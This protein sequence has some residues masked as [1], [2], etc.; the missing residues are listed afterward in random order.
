MKY[1]ILLCG[2]NYAAS[3]LHSFLKLPQFS[4]S[5][6]LA[7]GSKRSQ[8]L[9]S[10]FQVPLYQSVEAIN[11]PIDIAIVA[12]QQE[13][14]I[15]IAIQLMRKGIAV[16]LEHP[17]SNE[18]LKHLRR[19]S[20]Q[21]QVVFHVNPHFSYLP[22][23]EKFIQT[24]QSLNAST[25]PQVI[26]VHTSPR[27]LYS[28]LDILVKSFGQMFDLATLQVSSFQAYKV[29]SLRIN[30]IPF[31][32]NFQAWKSSKDNWSDSLSGHHIRISYH[33]GIL[34]LLGASG[35]CTWL[36]SP[37]Y[38]SPNDVLW[39]A[40]PKGSP[41]TLETFSKWRVHANQRSL[42]SLVQH[43]ETS[44]TPGDQSYLHLDYLTLFY[45]RFMLEFAPIMTKDWAP[46]EGL[47]SQK[48]FEFT[49]D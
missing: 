23:V 5:G 22:P 11:Q 47:P 27:C 42:L 12:V 28:V 14:A 41:P 40:L 24:T 46:T 17:V 45:D 6:I 44:A 37:L 15:D 18:G 32:I 19:E 10:L 16:L 8:D 36:K 4:F 35:M 3:Y 29:A 20:E 31:L 25:F 34:H 43:I 30:Q 13:I 26:E 38:A 21:N 9:A 48:L 1:N 7:K 2:S 33:D 39:E 49:E